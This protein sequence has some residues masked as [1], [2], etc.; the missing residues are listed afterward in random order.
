MV[1]LGREAADPVFASI[2]A[3]A[4]GTLAFVKDWLRIVGGYPDRQLES[5]A[6]AAAVGS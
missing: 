1:H 3:M 5:A 4:G 2:E 6:Q